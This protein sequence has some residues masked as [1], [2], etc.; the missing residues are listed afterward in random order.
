VHEGTDNKLWKSESLQLISWQT[1]NINV[2]FPQALSYKVQ[3]TESCT[4]PYGAEWHNYCLTAT[5]IRLVRV[6]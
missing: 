1:C 2:H 5:P 4:T 3:E 6:A